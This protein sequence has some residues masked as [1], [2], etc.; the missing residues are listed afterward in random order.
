MYLKNKVVTAGKAT[1]PN[2]LVHHFA[3]H[4]A[5]FPSEGKPQRVSVMGEGQIPFNKLGLNKENPVTT[6]FQLIARIQ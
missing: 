3:G 6:G 4:K 1:S 5:D 2:K